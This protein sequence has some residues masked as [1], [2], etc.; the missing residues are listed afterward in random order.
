M[1]D[2]RAYRMYAL[3]HEK[4]KDSAANGRAL[5]SSL[6]HLPVLRD[7]CAS[8]NRQSYGGATGVLFSL[9]NRIHELPEAFPGK[10]GVG[11]SSPVQRIGHFG[12]SDARFLQY[13]DGDH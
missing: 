8:C 2:V 12:D 13:S 4:S 3:G 11:V 7:T 5:P 1:Y 10:Y 6:S 9:F